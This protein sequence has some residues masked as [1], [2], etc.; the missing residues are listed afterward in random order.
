MLAND[1]ISETFG[2]PAEKLIGRPVLSVVPHSKLGKFLLDCGESR[3]KVLEL[4][5]PS[6]A[7]RT[8][9]TLKITAVR[10]G[11]EAQWK[12][13]SNAATITKR[14]GEAKLLLFENVTDRVILEQ[15]FVQAEKVAGMSQLA[16]SIAH[17]LANPLTSITYNLNFVRDS[18]TSLSN[19]EAEEALETTIERINEMRQLLSTL[20]GFVRHRQPKYEIADLHELIRRSIAF[21]SK[22]AEHRRI[23]LTLSLAPAPLVCEMDQRTINQVLLNLLKNAMEAMPI[24]GT[25]AVKTQLRLPDRDH[26]ETAIIEISDTG[27]GIEEAELRKIFRPLYSTKPHGMGLG[28]SFCRQIIEE[29]GGEIHLASRKGIGTTVALM[30][31]LRQQD[32]NE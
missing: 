3:S 23:Q 25:L 8:A 26:Q 2:I 19:R 6:R 4:E 17:E 9:M 12:K 13:K 30:L 22:D 32:A 11:A 24:G 10:L 15:Q 7:G 14:T 1:N 5:V 16:A 18:L 31:P 20:S 27:I 21:I 28:L 29:H